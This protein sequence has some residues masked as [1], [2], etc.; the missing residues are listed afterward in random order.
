MCYELL[1]RWQLVWK[2][3]LVDHLF[4]RK[5]WAG[6]LDTKEKDMRKLFKQ[7]YDDCLEYFKK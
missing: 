6:M 2:F 5:L 3:D 1:F 7:W 4:Y